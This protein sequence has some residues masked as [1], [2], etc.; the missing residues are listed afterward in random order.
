[1]HTLIA[2]PL[3]QPCSTST[4]ARASS[5]ARW[6]GVVA[7]RTAAPART[8]AR[9]GLVAGEHPAGQPTVHSTGGRGHGDL[10]AFG[11]RAQEPDVEAGVVGDQHRA[12]GELQE[13]GSTA[14]ISGASHTIAE[15]MPVSATICGGMLR[16][17]STSVAS[18]P[19]T[20]PPRTLTAPISVIASWPALWAG[21]RCLRSTT[22]NVVLPQ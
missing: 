11:G 20:A 18:S 14:S 1:V 8:A 5:S 6:V 17:G 9:W 3:D 7:R 13:R 15:V 12:A 21:R 10:A 19:S 22:T 16:P 2:D 4:V